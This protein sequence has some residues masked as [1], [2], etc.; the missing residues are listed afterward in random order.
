[1]TGTLLLPEP[2]EAV[3]ETVEVPAGVPVAAGGPPPE[4]VAAG[5]GESLLLQ[6]AIPIREIRHTAIHRLCASARRLY[7]NRPISIRPTGVNAYA[8]IVGEAPGENSATGPPLVV[9]VKVVFTGPPAGVTVAGLKL[10]AAPTGKFPQLKLT[11]WVN[12][13]SGVTVIVVEP[14]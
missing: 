13:A 5:G 1:M 8:N 7:H 11:G 6:L 12:P 14:F 4:L 10:Q 2:E 3:T 9:S